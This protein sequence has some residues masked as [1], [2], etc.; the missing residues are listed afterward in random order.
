[1]N[2]STATR[3]RTRDT[4]WKYINL[5]DVHEARTR[6][7]RRVKKAKGEDSGSER[8]RENVGRMVR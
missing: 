7:G 4:R 1:M 8:K 3:G 2:K 5:I 6:E